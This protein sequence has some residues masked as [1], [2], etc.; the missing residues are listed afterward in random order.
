MCPSVSLFVGPYVMLLLFGLLG[1]TYAVYTALLIHIYI[2]A[3]S[4]KRRVQEQ[5]HHVLHMAFSPVFSA[6]ATKTNGFRRRSILARTVLE[7]LN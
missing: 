5:F 4:R 2:L 6:V 1:A 3:Q 7:H